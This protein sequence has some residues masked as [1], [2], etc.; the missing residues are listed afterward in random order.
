MA[1]TSDLP[2]PHDPLA[3]PVG[4]ARPRRFA[5]IG[6]GRAGGALAGALE[7]VG[8]QRVATYGRGDDPRHAAAGV[9]LVVVAVPDRAIA[10]AAAAVEPADEAVIVHLAG[11]LGVDVLGAHP[12]RGGIHP[13]VALADPAA[14][15]RRLAA[16]A[17]FAVGGSTERARTLLDAVVADLGGH[18]VHVADA[19]RTRYHAA[20]CIASNH[21]VALLGQVERVAASVGV[22]VEAFAD[23]VAGK[24]GRAHV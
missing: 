14:G 10:E 15:A 3:A 11:S 5:L 8:W 23:L 1:G 20:A 13:L 7:S 4:D 21:L 6:P 17:W 19:D 2:R 18:A 22:P 9:D 16:G 12:H 24:I